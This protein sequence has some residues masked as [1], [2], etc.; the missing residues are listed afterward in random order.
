MKKYELIEHTADFGLKVY[1]KNLAELFRNAAVALFE[2]IGELRRVKST[3]KIIIELK[4]LNLDELFIGWLREMLYQFNGK[5]I[6]LKDFKIKKIS[7]TE[8]SA[9][10]FGEELDLGKHRLNKEIKAVTY[11]ELSVKKT[12]F[13]YEAQVIFDI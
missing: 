2:N 3:K 10:V 13:G 9:E 1:G 8:I 6:L 12:N 11:H 7:D 5:E 4:A